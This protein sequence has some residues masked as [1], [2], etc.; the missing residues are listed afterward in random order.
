MPSAVSWIGHFNFF[1][2]NKP[3][4]NLISYIL[5]LFNQHQGKSTHEETSISMQQRSCNL[6]SCL[7]FC[8]QLIYLK[9][10]QNKFITSL[11]AGKNTNK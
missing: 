11:G 2:F 1:C 4:R 5:P 9:D 6:S 3:I 8:L 7:V 10:H